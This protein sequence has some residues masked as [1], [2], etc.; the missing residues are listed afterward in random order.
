MFASD[1]ILHDGVGHP[2]VAGTFPRILGHYVREPHEVTLMDALRRMT[3]EPG[4]RLEHRVPS[5]ARKGRLRVGADAD[6]VLFD[7][8]TVIDRAT[9]REPMLPPV[10]V[11][12]VIVGG[13][14]VVRDGRLMP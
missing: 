11:P 7:P 10:G 12:H 5:M 14:P 3:L 6:V 13:T 2:R 8:A 1:G 9:Y 4:R